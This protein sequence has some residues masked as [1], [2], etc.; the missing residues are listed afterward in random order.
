MGHG[1]GGQLY[2]A[3]RGNAHRHLVRTLPWVVRAGS[4]A[5]EELRPREV[6]ALASVHIVGDQEPM[7]GASFI[8]F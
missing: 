8:W 6:N 2:T 7:M 3:A 1:V 5:G 4:S